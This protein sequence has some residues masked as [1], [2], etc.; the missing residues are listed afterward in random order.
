[1]LEVSAPRIPCR[2]FAAFLDLRY[3]IKTFTRAAKPGAYLRVIAP[4][5]VRAGDTITVD[6]RPEHNVTVGLVF[7]ARTSESELLPQL[8]AADAL[9]A[10]LK[11]YARERT[12]SP[13]PVDSADDV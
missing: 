7:R 2:T 5:T 1:M 3:W 13:P 6:Y 4:G 12:P 10:E 9:A 8:L 11:A